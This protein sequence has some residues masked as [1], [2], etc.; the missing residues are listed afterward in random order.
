MG[1]KEAVLIIT[2]NENTPMQ[3][4][5]ILVVAKMIECKIFIRFLIFALHIVSNEYPQYMC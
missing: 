4:N 5:A 2:Q 1:Q 3:Y